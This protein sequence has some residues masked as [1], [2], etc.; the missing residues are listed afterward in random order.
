M[1]NPIAFIPTE[2]T[3]NSAKKINSSINTSQS[4]NTSFN[5]LLSREIS[6]KKT[7]NKDNSASKV[8]NKVVNKNAETKQKVPDDA[9]KVQVK[10]EDETKDKLESD[11]T[12][13]ESTQTNGVQFIALVESMTQFSTKTVSPLPETTSTEISLVDTSTMATTNASLTD[14]EALESDKKNDSLFS[15]Q[16]EQ[17]NVSDIGNENTLATIA[18]NTFKKPN[19]SPVTPLPAPLSDPSLVNKGGEQGA[20]QQILDNLQTDVRL[21]M[22][23][24]LNADSKADV[25]VDLSMD[26]KT[27]IKIDPKAELKTDPKI[28]ISG[29]ANES[30]L[31][32][33][34][35]SPLTQ[36]FAQQI[37]ISSGQVH[38][39]TELEH[40]TPR[41]G[42]SAWDQAVGQKVIWMVAGGKQTAELTLNPP[43]L[44]PMQVVLSINNDQANATFISAHSDVREALESA[45][46]KLRQM[47]DD[48]GVQLSSFSVKSEASNQGNQSAE[49]RSFSRSKSNATE[50]IAGIDSVATP[51]TIRKSSGLGIVDTFA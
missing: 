51:D 19:D 22:K 39:S 9:A 28:Q 6:A 48:A 34:D 26:P 1:Q 10:K 42:T 43:D 11:Q 32:V 5:Q 13:L 35:V 36:N 3:G 50:T 37:A 40:L 30:G 12:S 44:G 8:E 27:E 29:S 47:M 2:P 45:M 49:D 4:V 18:G 41:V 33:S 31:K 23:A 14:I 21:D 38:A 24:D 20:T 16:A 7:I 46:P 15:F 25:T 17:E